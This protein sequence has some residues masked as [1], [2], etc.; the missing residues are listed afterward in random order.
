[1]KAAGLNLNYVENVQQW[2]SMSEASSKGI[3]YVIET[4]ELLKGVEN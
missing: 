2:L 4:Y 1:M 3:D